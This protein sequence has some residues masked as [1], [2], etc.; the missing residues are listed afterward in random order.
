MWVFFLREVW[1]SE[2]PAS[3]FLRPSEMRRPPMPAAVLRTWPAPRRQVCQESSQSFSPD[4]DSFNCWRP[5]VAPCCSKERTGYAGIRIRT[6]SDL[7]LGRRQTGSS[8][9]QTSLRLPH[10]EGVRS[11]KTLNPHLPLL[12]LQATGFQQALRSE[13]RRKEQALQELWAQSEVGATAQSPL[14]SLGSCV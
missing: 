5:S 8:A 7:Q 11:S 10:T 1:V 6:I 3:R 12:N 4:R 14:Q 9:T 13:L 2:H